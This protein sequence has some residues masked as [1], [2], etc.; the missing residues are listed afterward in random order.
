MVDQRTPGFWGVT[1]SV[2]SDDSI[3]LVLY[4]LNPLQIL[5][6]S[7]NSAGFRDRWK[8][9]GEAIYCVGFDDNTFRSG[10]HGMMV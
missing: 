9:S 7:S 3:I 5:E 2:V 1:P 8:Y 4:G 6:S 10:L